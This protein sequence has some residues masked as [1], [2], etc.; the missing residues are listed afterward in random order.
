M[1]YLLL[2]ALIILA[3]AFMFVFSRPSTIDDANAKGRYFVFNNLTGYPCFGGR[4]FLTRRGA[5]RAFRKLRVYPLLAF[6][7]M[8]EIRKVL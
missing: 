5:I 2:I 3:V 7:N 4:T 8:Y 1:E 6:P